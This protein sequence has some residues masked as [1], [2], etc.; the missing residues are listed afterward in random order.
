[1]CHISTSYSRSAMELISSLRSACPACESPLLQRRPRQRGAVQCQLIAEPE[2]LHS[3]HVSKMCP[4]CP[5]LQKYWCGFKEVLINAKW[6]KQVDEP[7]PIYF[8]VSKKLGVVA[9]WLRRWRYRMYL[10]RASFLHEAVLLRL[11]DPTVQVQVRAQLASA[12]GREI[13]WR[14]SADAE[15]AVRERLASQLLALPLEKLLE[16]HWSWYEPMMFQR[17]GSGSR[18][19]KFFVLSPHLGLFSF[20]FSSWGR[21][22]TQLLTSGNRLDICAIDGNAQLHRRTCGQPHAEVVHYPA[23]AKYLLRACSRS[24]RGKETLCPLHASQ[25]DSGLQARRGEGEIS[26]HRLKRALFAES[27]VNYLE[28]QLE[29]YAGWQPAE[30]VNQTLLNRYFAKLADAKIRG[31][32]LKKPNANTYPGIY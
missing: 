30:T 20:A 29:G 1:M 11:L 15:P 9:S 19:S 12:W 23:I 28:V 17:Q 26:A 32:H 13:L 4:R 21:R 2:T 24:P 22:W 18:I 16:L 25:R 31:R 5:P 6:V 14:R 10:H 27:D 8:F 7:H 3:W